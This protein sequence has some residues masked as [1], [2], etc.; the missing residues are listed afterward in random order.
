M[1]AMQS[2]M[3]RRRRGAATEAM[4]AMAALAVAVAVALAVAMA[5]ARPHG[6]ESAPVVKGLAPALD[7][8]ERFDGTAE[9]EGMVLL[10]LLLQSQGYKANGE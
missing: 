2:S 10:L 5:P 3:A 9:A 8:F 6:S 7:F 1:V 4:A